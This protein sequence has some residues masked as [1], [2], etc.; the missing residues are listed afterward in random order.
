MLLSGPGA[1]GVLGFPA[2]CAFSVCCGGT[3]PTA[4]P[5]RAPA[6]PGRAGW[7]TSTTLGSVWPWDVGFGGQ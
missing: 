7:A 3:E 2:A 6:K 4:L 1:F 5:R